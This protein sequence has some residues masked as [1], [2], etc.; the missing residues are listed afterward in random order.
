MQDPL[1]LEVSEEKVRLVVS[2]R[3]R[4][5]CGSLYS[6]GSLQRLGL[7]GKGTFNGQV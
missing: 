1:T 5:Q 2:G 6:A 3:Y 7:P 4:V